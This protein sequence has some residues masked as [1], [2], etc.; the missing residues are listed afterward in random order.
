M[1]APLQFLDTRKLRSKILFLGKYPWALYFRLYP[2]NIYLFR[3]NKRSTGKKVWNMLT[4]FSIKIPERHQWR[5]SG[6]LIVKFEHISHL[7]SSVSIVDFE[8]L[9]VRWVLNNLEI[10]RTASYCWY[11][12]LV[13]LLN[14]YFDHELK[15]NLRLSGLRLGGREL[16]LW[17]FKSGFPTTFQIQKYSIVRRLN[18]TNHPEWL[19]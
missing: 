12:K 4:K 7:L 1:N 13:K 11:K 6:I 9:N 18:P 3:V 15:C 2:A 19:F 17:K 8:Q 10:F 16:G 5:H 14:H